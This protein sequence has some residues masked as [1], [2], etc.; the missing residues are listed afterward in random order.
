M[1]ARLFFCLFEKIPRFFGE[2][3]L[4]KKVSPRVRGLVLR[5]FYADTIERDKVAPNMLTGRVGGTAL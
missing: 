2:T 5:K 1:E 3:S 4:K